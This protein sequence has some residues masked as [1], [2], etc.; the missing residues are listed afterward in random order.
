MIGALLNHKSNITSQVY[1]QL[2]ELG[3]KRTLVNT[4]AKIIRTALRHRPKLYRT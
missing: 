4:G 2:A 1:V 3:V